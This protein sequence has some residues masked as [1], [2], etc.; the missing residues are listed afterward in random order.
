MVMRVS[1]ASAPGGITSVSF[2]SDDA[3]RPPAAPIVNSLGAPMAMP[4]AVG[5]PPLPLVPGGPAGSSEEQ[6]VASTVAT[7]RTMHRYAMRSMAM[8]H[9]SE[10]LT[11][12][13]RNG[14]QCRKRNQ[15]T[16]GNVGL[17]KVVLRVDATPTESSI[18]P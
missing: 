12:P 14:A 13:R 11:T 9:G 5:V 18:A 16:V 4:T 15:G 3:R 7:P 8:P 6:P 17:Q 1:L 2:P 10:N